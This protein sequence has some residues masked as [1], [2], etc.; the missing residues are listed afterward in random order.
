MKKTILFDMDGLMINSEV[1][2]KEEYFSLLQKMGYPVDLSFYMSLLGKNKPA[3]YDSFYQE[4]GDAFPMDEVWDVVHIAIDRRILKE[5]PIKKGLLPLLHYLK[6]NKYQTI[7]ATSSSSN[8]VDTILDALDLKKYFDDV[9]CGDEVSKGKP[10]PEIFLKGCKKLN[11]N[12]KEAIV[13]EDSEAGVLAAHNANIDV[14]C[15]PD[16][17]MPSEEIAEKAIIMDSLEDVLVYLKNNKN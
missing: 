12:P 6:E 3:I 11:V 15:I 4:Y 8:R 9:I 14:I 16:L 1:I 5:K 2:T 17:K 10:N 13:L 7:V